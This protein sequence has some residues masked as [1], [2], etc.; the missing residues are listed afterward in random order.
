MNYIITGSSQGIGFEISKMLQNKNKLIICSRKKNKFFESYSKNITFIKSDLTKLK[1]IK[2]INKYFKKNKIKLDGAIFCQ[3]LL[4]SPFY[5]YDKKK[6][7]YWQKIFDTN[8]TS[9]LNLVR[10]ILPFIRKKSFSKIIFFSGGGSFNTWP[11]FSAYSTSKTALVRYA[12]NLADEIKDQKTIVNCLAPGFLNT[13]IHKKN[14]SV[15]NSLNI[16]YKNELKKNS[17]KKPNFKNILSLVN[18]ILKNKNLS[19]S[20]RTISANFDPW[21]LK[22]FKTKLKK[23]QKSLKLIREN[24]KSN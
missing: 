16:K 21:K 18:Y 11:K 23:N 22:S 1:D 15:L 19:L 17:K 2:K 5:S 10:Y 4:G 12:E 9:N 14:Y 7:K 24:L 3:G 20:G 8:F 13:N 6:Y